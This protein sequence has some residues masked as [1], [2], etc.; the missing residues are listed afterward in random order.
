M[1]N[2]RVSPPLLQLDTVI[3]NELLNASNDAHDWIELRNVTAADVDLSGWS[4]IVTSPE[5]GIAIAFPDGTVLA[6]GEV[7]LFVN[8]DPGEPNIAVGSV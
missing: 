1:R 7:L 3:F 2:G 6:A 8:T 4:L 5:G